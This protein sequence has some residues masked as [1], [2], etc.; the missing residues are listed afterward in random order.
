M[1]TIDALVSKKHDVTVYDV[2]AIR[3]SL[4]GVC[5]HMENV[6]I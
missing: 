5:L 2:D 3:V 6:L 4:D 1:S